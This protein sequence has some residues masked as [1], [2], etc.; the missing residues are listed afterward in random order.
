MKKICH[1]HFK[2]PFETKDSKHLLGTSGD[3]L[4]ALIEFTPCTGF[5]AKNMWCKG[6]FVYKENGMGKS[7]IMKEMCN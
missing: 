3:D 6:Q 4:S 7:P 1:I 5:Q 2:F